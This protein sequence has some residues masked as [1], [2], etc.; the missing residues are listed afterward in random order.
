MERKKKNP[1]RGKLE[2]D[3][4]RNF[5]TVKN[6]FSA[7]LRTKIFSGVVEDLK[8]LISFHLGFQ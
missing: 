2:I 1:L 4:F 5:S 8:G 7:Q 3:G 6:V